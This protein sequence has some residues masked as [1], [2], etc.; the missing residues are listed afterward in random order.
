MKGAYVGCRILSK[1]DRKVTLNYL[2][3]IIMLYVLLF[4]KTFSFVFTLV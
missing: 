3:R 4:I 2:N 1:V